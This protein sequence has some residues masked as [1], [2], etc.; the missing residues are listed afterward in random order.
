MRFKLQAGMKKR[1]GV[2]EVVAVII[3]MA[4][5]ATTSILALGA[6]SKQTLDSEKTVADALHDKGAQIQ[7]LLSVIQ[8]DVQPDRI[9][10]EV[11]NYGLKDIVLEVVLVDG[12]KTTYLLHDNNGQAFANNTIPQGKIMVLEIGGVGGSVQLITDTQNLIELKIL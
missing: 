5:I 12:K 8:Q 4:V 2:G 11:L 1:R 9:R 7:E 3:L 6:S 10:L